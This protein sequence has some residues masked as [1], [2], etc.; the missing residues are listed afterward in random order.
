MGK[1][2]CTGISGQIPDEAI[3]GLVFWADRTSWPPRV[4]LRNGGEWGLCPHSHGDGALSQAGKSQ[5]TP[6]GLWACSVYE[7]M[8]L[9]FPKG[10]YVEG[11]K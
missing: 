10:Q 9:R 2:V 6:Q 11:S 3:F 1:S 8:S 5:K 4:L 7:A